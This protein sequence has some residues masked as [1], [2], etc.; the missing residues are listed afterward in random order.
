MPQWKEQYGQDHILYIDESGINSNETA[1][2]GWSQR[3]QQCHALR[4]GGHGTRLSMIG[5]VRS[6]APFTFIQPLV[7]KGSCDRS[8]FLCWLEYLLQ[9]LQ[10][11]DIQTKSYLLILDNASIHKGQVIDDLV[12]RYQTRI[13]I[14]LH[15]APISIR[16]KKHGLS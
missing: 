13:F 11:K 9:G 1:E 5:A 16:L 7:F 3:G 2:Y 12:A 15:I 6:N 4:L 8:I 10:Q 14:Y